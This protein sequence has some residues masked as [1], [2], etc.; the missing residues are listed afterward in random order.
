MSP[1]Q[2]EG[3][4]LDHRSDIFSFGAVL[5]ELLTGNR[6]FGGATAL[7]ALRAVTTDE[8]PPF[9]APASVE[10]IVRRCLRKRPA[11]RF[12]TMAEVN[13]ALE[14]CASADPA[15]PARA[16]IAVL[17]FA[18][19]SCGPR[20]RVFQRRAR[21]RNHQRPRSGPGAEGHRPHLRL[22]LQG[23]ERGRPPDRR[24]PR[25][26]ARARGQRSQGRQPD[27]RHRAVDRRVG[28]QPPV[29]GALRPRDG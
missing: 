12:Q 17:A 3:G 22:R 4:P 2:A 24:H 5:Y 1:E 21:R 7:Q 16:S 11:D 13:A 25:R 18:N 29:V 19:M 20:G 6:A 28:R 9:E 14:G 10:R 8:P 26:R 27:P 15:P 23:Q